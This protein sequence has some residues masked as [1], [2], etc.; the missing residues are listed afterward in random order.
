MKI[1][2]EHN[3][4]MEDYDPRKGYVE[5]DKI[6]V[7]RHE[8]IEAI[9][10]QG[11]YEVVKEYPN[12]GKD[13]EWVVDTPAVEGKDAWDE[14]ETILRYIPYNERQLAQIEIDELKGE[15]FNTD[16]IALKIIEGAATREEYA[17]VIE[18]RA[19]WRKRINELETKM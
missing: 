13:V 12:G 11:H 18:Q 19:K 5:T 10:E 1:L 3:I 17:D 2:D 14:Y 16:Y 6:L 4:E 8:A 15:L 9:E 7:V